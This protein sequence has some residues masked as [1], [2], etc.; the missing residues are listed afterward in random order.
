MSDSLDSNEILHLFNGEF[1]SISCYCGSFLYITSILNV[2]FLPLKMLK[3]H[4]YTINVFISEKI[5]VCTY[6]CIL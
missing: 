3:L 6:M 2:K 5:T 1:S 4:T